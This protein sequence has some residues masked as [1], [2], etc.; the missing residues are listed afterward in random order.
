MDIQFQQIFASSNIENKHTLYCG[1]RCM[2]KLCSS[3]RE[4]FNVRNFKKKKMLPITKE[5]LKSDEDAKLCYICAK[6][7]LQK[8][9]KNKNY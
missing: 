9:A 6:R 2:K 7:I 4:F 3:L 8:F 1:K 5:E